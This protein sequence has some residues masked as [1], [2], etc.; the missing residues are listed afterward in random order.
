MGWKAVVWGEGG[1]EV[2]TS[3]RNGIWWLSL[4]KPGVMEYWS[5]GVVIG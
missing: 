4:S 3:W 5:D 1:G 2:R